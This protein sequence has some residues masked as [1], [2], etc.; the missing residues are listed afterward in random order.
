MRDT[1]HDNYAS[2][3]EC[4]K[5]KKEALKHNNKVTKVTAFCLRRVE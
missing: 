3:K 5:A 2:L 4:N 1:F